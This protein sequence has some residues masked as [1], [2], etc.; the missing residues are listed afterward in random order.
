MTIALENDR[1]RYMGT[2][3]DINPKTGALELYVMGDFVS[4]WLPGT[5]IEDV[6]KIALCD[7]YQYGKGKSPLADDVTRLC[8]A[9]IA[10]LERAQKAPAETLEECQLLALNC[11]NL[12]NKVADLLA[13]VQATGKAN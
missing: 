5:K 6:M 13:T 2:G 10:A 8:S 1:I 3:I 4:G 7:T 11:H 9:L 12:T